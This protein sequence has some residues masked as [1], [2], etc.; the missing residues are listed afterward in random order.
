M[1]V[2]Y[3]IVAVLDVYES[4][5]PET[6]GF[7]IFQPLFGLILVAI[8]IFA[9]FLVGLPIRLH[10]IANR[11]WRAR[12]TIPLIGIITGL[13]LIAASFHPTLMTQTELV[14]DGTRVNKAIP[15]VGLAVGGWFLTSFSLLH[16]FPK[17]LINLMQ[18]FFA[19]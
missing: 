1:F 8:T 13:G 2:V 7:L 17:G 16:W 3:M 12:Q 18:K 15:N 5:V 14:I 4:G 19:T 11:W 6:I 9:C 10:Q